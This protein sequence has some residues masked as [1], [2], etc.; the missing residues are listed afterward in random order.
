MVTFYIRTDGGCRPPLH[1]CL[2]QLRSVYPEARVIVASD[3]KEADPAPETVEK[4]RIDVK[5]EHGLFAIEHGAALLHYMLGH[6]LEMPTPWLIKIDPDTIIWRRFR[7]LPKGMTVFGYVQYAGISAVQGGCEGFTLAAAERMY[8]SRMLRNPIFKDPTKWATANHII[9]YTKRTGCITEDW[10]IGYVAHLLGIPITACPE[11][12]SEWNKPVTNDK[13]Y[14]ATHPHKDL[15]DWP[16]F[17]S[18][19]GSPKS[20]PRLFL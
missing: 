14:A 10:I 9:E 15:K 11:I 1:V 17:A 19:V 18:S 4:Y 5:H 20:N 12:L 2:S 16:M 3:D 7:D 6:Y 8:D 13:D